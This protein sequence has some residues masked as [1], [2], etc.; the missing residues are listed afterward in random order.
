MCHRLTPQVASLTL[1]AEAVERL[2]R[3]EWARTSAK[4]GAAP[5][6]TTLGLMA[7][8]G[9]VIG[10]IAFT[11]K[12]KQQN[13]ESPNGQDDRG[14]IAWHV[15]Q[16]KAKGETRIRVPAFIGEMAEVPSLDYAIEHFRV[17]SAHPVEKFT[18]IGSPWTL[19]TWYKLRVLDTLSSGTLNAEHCPGCETV[20]PNELL[21]VDPDEILVPQPGGILTVDG[22]T[23]VQL[24]GPLLDSSPL[25]NSS[26]KG[27]NEQLDYTQTPHS[28]ITNPGKLVLFLSSIDSRIAWKLPLSEKG[29]LS[30]SASGSLQ[31]MDGKRSVITRH[32]EDHRITSHDEFKSYV[33][34]VR[35]RQ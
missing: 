9:L 18:H 24:G 11:S 3:F 5:M 14:T 20:I 17:V 25:V 31:P 35:S 22:V 2:L 12:Q 33:H 32:L 13:A 16:A 21:P 28:H 27:T 7:L 29:I 26:D 15:R 19:V 23:I 6:K 8:L 10:G 4:G 34:R 30:L 1:I